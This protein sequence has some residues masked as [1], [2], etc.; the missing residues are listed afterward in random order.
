VQLPQ[1]TAASNRYRQSVR[2]RNPGH[3]PHCQSHAE[4]MPRFQDAIPDDPQRAWQRRANPVLIDPL[5]LDLESTQRVLEF[6]EGVKIKN[7]SHFILLWG[8]RLC[9]RAKVVVSHTKCF[10]FHSTRLETSGLQP[11]GRRAFVIRRLSAQRGAPINLPSLL[12][13]T[14]EAHRSC[15]GFPNC[16]QCHG[17]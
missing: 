12:T 11:S 17:S 16:F 14:S 4:K 8:T 3:R 15:G 6:V 7:D 13:A 1:T 5:H 9:A 10:P 2:R